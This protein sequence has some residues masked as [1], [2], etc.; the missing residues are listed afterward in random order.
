M[1]YFWVFRQPSPELFIDLNEG[2]LKDIYGKGKN[3]KGEYGT[4]PR[5]S[6]MYD[7]ENKFVLDGILSSIHSSE[8]FMIEAILQWGLS[9]T[10]IS[11]V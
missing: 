3:Q 2:M 1:A 8:G 11:M 6:I 10:T 7:L 9:N 5:V 4:T